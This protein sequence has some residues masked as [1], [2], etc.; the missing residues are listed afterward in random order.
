M[1]RGD[2][3]DDDRPTPSRMQYSGKLP[4]ATRTECHPDGREPWGWPVIRSPGFSMAMPPFPR[5]WPFGWRRS[6]G[7]TPGS[8]YG[9]RPL[10]TW[11]RH[12]GL[13]TALRF[14]RLRYHRL[15]VPRPPGD[16]IGTGDPHVLSCPHHHA[17]EAVH[18]GLVFP[19]AVDDQDWKHPPLNRP[20][21]QCNFHYNV[22]KILEAS[23]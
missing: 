22:C 18:G 10:T 3:N 16:P 19:V 21:I 6:V 8:G 5:K 2:K 9:A 4:P 14:S 17:Y 13:P 1:N 20:S 23:K 15:Q 12:A 11:C 7:R